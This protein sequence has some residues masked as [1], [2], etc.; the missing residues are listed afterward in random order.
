MF[1]PE[2]L[3]SDSESKTDLF[4]SSRRFF[5][6]GC[7]FTSVEAGLGSICSG[8]VAVVPCCPLLNFKSFLHPGSST[9]AEE[10]LGSI[11]S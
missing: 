3:S 9:S 11:F 5:R 7:S 6:S 4:V 2:E 1:P 10:R 8:L